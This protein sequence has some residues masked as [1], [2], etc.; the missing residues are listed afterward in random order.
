MSRFP[1]DA[2]G[3]GGG[4]GERDRQY[5]DPE[6]YKIV[7]FDQRGAGKSTPSAS[8]EKNTT[9]DLVSDIEKLREHLKIDKWVV[10]G[11]SWGSTLSLAYAQTHPARVKALVLRGIFTL[12]KS[13]LRFLSQDGTSH[14]F[15]D[16][17][18]EYLAPIPE[19]E[20]GDLM[21]AY[22]KRLTSEDDH[23]RTQTAKAWS[24]WVMSTSK[25]RVDP[26]DIARAG[27]DE[28]ALALARISS[29]Y[30]VNAGFMREGQPLE[31]Q[32]IDKI[33]HIPTVIIQGRYDVVCPARSAYDL[34]KV[35]PEAELIIVPDAGHS[36]WEVPTS[37]LLTE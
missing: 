2:G 34:K 14:I 6:A 35:F 22:H 31:K 17:W 4:T 13:E 10:F 23:V 16:A 37:K 9:W 36:P 28:W 26:K 24:K 32:E 20:W 15:P 12:R 33:R 7:L 30:F 29:H 3:P 25:L 11:G 19:E 27:Q 8:V 18:D 5:F 21:T 1:Y